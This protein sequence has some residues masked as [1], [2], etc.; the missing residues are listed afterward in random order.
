RFIS[1]FGSFSSIWLILGWVGFGSFLD[2]E[3]YFVPD[4]YLVLEVS[5][6]SI[7]VTFV[8]VKLLGA[9]ILVLALGSKF[10]SIYRYYDT[11][12]FTE[13]EGINKNSNLIS[14]IFGLHNLILQ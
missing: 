6:F 12:L 9:I 13:V 10:F 2:P 8:I 5:S 1:S 4:F 7:P 11:Q 3:T 14:K